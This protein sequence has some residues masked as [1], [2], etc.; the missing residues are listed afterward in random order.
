[1]EDL[2]SEDQNLGLGYKQALVWSF[3]FGLYVWVELGKTVGHKKLL[4]NYG[5]QV[6]VWK[7]KQGLC[8]A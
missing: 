8:G 5:P 1:M 2:K 6:Y 7:L 3:E 4:V